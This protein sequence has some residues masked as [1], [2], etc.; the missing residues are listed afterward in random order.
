L[1]VTWNNHLGS[2][3]DSGRICLQCAD[4]LTQ[5]LERSSEVA[6]N[7]TVYIDASPV[8]EAVKWKVKVL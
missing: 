6:T 3:N 4:R 5:L 7:V 1:H 2:E 8:D